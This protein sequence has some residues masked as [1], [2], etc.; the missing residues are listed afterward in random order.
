[1]NRTI[2]QYV[3]D[4]KDD[5]YFKL[6][7][8]DNPYSCIRNCSI[9][10]PYCLKCTK[11]NCSK[12]IIE[13]S[14]NGSCFP[15]I[16]NCLKY[17]RH[18][19]GNIEY[20]DCEICDQNNSYYCINNIR[21]KCEFVNN[22]ANF[23][24]IEDSEFSCLNKCE[25]TFPECISCNR[26][27]CF[28]CNEDYVV[29]NKNKTKCIPN[30]KRPD[31]DICN[32]TIDYDI[33]INIKELEFEYFIDFYFI[34]LLPYTNFVYHFVNENY[35]VTIFINSECTEELLNEGYFKIDSKE[36]YNEMYKMA[37]IESNELLFS[38][39]LKYN[40]QNHY[41]F[42]NIYTQYLNED[43][44][45]PNCKEIPFTV[46]YKYITVFFSNSFSF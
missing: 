21:N 3:K 5:E 14:K 4:Y 31:D 46:T 33:N 1:M 25:E 16:S 7:S 26:T 36:L 24:K 2:C 45:C 37:E 34:N 18:E 6:E 9:E 32:L 19:E 12:C 20:L 42:Y 15:P 35:T 11:E 30:I 23:Y 8:E 44:I 39:F 22:I 10:F 41:R 40:H 17:E 13:K 38:I 43:E 28:E 27:Y 29:S